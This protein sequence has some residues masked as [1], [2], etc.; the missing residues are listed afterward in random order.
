MTPIQLPNRD[1]I[2]A[3]YP[4]GEEA[5]V[6]L[7][8]TLI[9][10]I[11]VL[12]ARIQALEDQLAK[13][14]HNSSKP[15][16]SDGLKKKPKSVRHPSGKKSGGQEGHPGHRLESVANPKYVKVHPVSQCRHCQAGLVAVKVDEYEKRQV[17]DLPVV[18]LE[19]TEHQAEIKTC[20]VCG[21]I[22]EAAFPA[23]VTQETQYGPRVR[24]QLVYFNAYPFIPVDL[25]QVADEVVSDLETQISR[26]Q[27][28]VLIEQ[29]PVIEG[30]PTQLHQ[31]LQNLIANALKFQKPDM[32]IEVKVSS[33]T[34]QAESDR[35]TMVSILVKDNGIGF[36]EQYFEQ[37]L[38][39]FQRLHGRSEYEGNG[40][41]LSIV[42]KIIDRHQGEFTAHSQ[43]GQGSTFCITLPRNQNL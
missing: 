13:D 16:A 34:F 27:G 29:L 38:Q 14:S 8:E 15:P 5:V 43:P 32:P 7:V 35:R 24:A 17:F 28:R 9:A 39:P 26:V 6:S 11:R 2:R 36:E 41:G 25:S 37:I 10:T 3:I 4:Q 12:E 31:V 40:M 21:E 1:E 23:D 33:V 19:V 20:P 42:K 22:T 18:E 30:D